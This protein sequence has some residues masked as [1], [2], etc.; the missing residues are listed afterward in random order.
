MKFPFAKKKISISTGL[1]YWFCGVTFGVVAILSEGIYLLSSSALTEQST[2]RLNDLATQIST[3][4]DQGMYERYRE[5]QNLARRT[6]VADPKV[7]V[8]GRE[9]LFN[10]IASTYPQY[11]WIGLT[12]TNGKVVAAKDGMLRGVDVSAR[13]WY[14]GA[15]NGI[16]VGDVHEAKLL[17]KKL[18]VI[19]GEPW[20]FV[21]LAFPVKSKAGELIGTLG[22]HMSWR[23]AEDVKKSVID[24]EQKKGKLEAL[25]INSQGSVILGPKELIGARMSAASIE[26]K[27]S[28]DSAN[29]LDWTN[30]KNYLV[31]ASKTQGHQDFPGLG[32][33]VVVR[34]PVKEALAP[35]WD[36]RAG[37]M[38]FGAAMALIFS[39]VGRYSAR[40]ITRS[41]RSLSSSAKDIMDGKE[42]RLL[43][44][45]DSYPEVD[46]LWQSLSALIETH[47]Q[48]EQNLIVLNAGL[49]A[50]VAERT[51]NLEVS[52]K[53]LRTITNNLPALIAYLDT[54]LR[55]QFMNSTYTAWYDIDTDLAIGKTIDEVH[56]KSIFKEVLPY[57]EKARK[58]VATS[59]ELV[60]SCDNVPQYLAFSCIPDVQSG[61]TIGYY[62]LGQDITEARVHQKQLEHQVI[63]DALTKLPN[64][65]GCMMA[66]DSALDRA[67]RSKN[68]VAVMFLDLN[69]F[70][71]VNDTYGHA[72]GDA[73]LIEFAKR[74]KRTVR[75]TDTVARLSGDEFVIVAENLIEG[76]ANSQL[77]AENIIEAMQAPMTFEGFNGVVNTSIGIAIHET[78]KTNSAAL[79]VRAD[80]A[81]YVAKQSQGS[82]F[83]IANEVP[84]Q[85]EI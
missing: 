79:L 17:A 49:E 39:L 44:P 56:G 77:I 83:H 16:F 82:A 9:N 30:R 5:V 20:R 29:M 23:W 80:E 74:L 13:D 53:R 85:P 11:A 33:T 28:V 43:V 38:M 78:G 42:V 41:I 68:A 15:N 52:Q 12:D 61:T 25:I 37:V 8:E 7:T 32:W 22:V 58:G 67:K 84:F 59:F 55:Y 69:K 40:R 70:K 66:I 76:K 72:V 47:A 6:E 10:D 4:L 75:E 31:G 14:I 2:Q 63:H 19:N 26:G 35:V 51:R 71:A 36:L 48:H 1:T 81:M 46:Q 57:I 18:P 24:P 50:R 54:D 27:P 21:D 65:Q 62:V 45:K 3:H 64:R 60:R 34:Q 73:V